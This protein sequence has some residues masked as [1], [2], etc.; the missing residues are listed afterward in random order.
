MEW[1]Q[2]TKINMKGVETMKI[3]NNI[4]A[5]ECTKGSYV[6][7]IL[8]KEIILI[9][10]GLSW[11]GNRIVKE[12]S[13]M[14]IKLEDIKHILLTHHDLDHIGS[15]EKLRKLTGAT[16]WASKED[17][18]YITGET[19]RPGFK[20][21]LPYI[22]RVKRPQVVTPYTRGSKIAQVEIISTPGH[23]KGHVCLLYEDV[24]FAGDLVENKKGQLSA[25]PSFWNWNTAVLKDSIKKL[26]NY[27][28]NWVCPAHGKPVKR[29]EQ[30][31]QL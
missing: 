30:W 9:D 7:V 1:L 25:Y 20:K 23:T 14:N 3:T 15:A 6:Y 4:Y 21:F 29:G 31:A 11:A 27:N 26:N 28:F 10:T 8:G 18:P 17:I 16:L 12:L 24:L 13:S 5:L 2:I 22:F 19:H